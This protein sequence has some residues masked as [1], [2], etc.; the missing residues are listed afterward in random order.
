MDPATTLV[1]RDEFALVIIDIQER[2]AAAMERRD[3]VVR[4]VSRLARTAAMLDAPLI[5]TRQ[6]PQGLG[7]TVPELETVLGALTDEGA[8]ISG[9]DK[10]AFCCAAEIDFTKALR[11]TGR[12]QVVLVGMET[13]IC[14]TQTALALAAEGY[15]VHVVADACCSRET[16]SHEVAL[17]RLRQGVC[18]TTSESVMYEAVGRA[19]TDEFRRLLAIVKE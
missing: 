14:V 17:D 3:E 12:R 19:G 5:V 7:P 18:V 10:T 11:A 6:Y 13:H 4:T 1:S 15:D 2:L 16:A 8:R 9:V